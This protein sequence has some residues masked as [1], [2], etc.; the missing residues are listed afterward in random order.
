MHWNTIKSKLDTVKDRGIIR[1]TISSAS[2]KINQSYEDSSL[3]YS[4]NSNNSSIFLDKT[5]YSIYDKNSASN[6]KLYN[7]S[8]CSLVSLASNIQ[9]DLNALPN[10]IN[11]D[12]VSNSDSSPI[13]T[14]EL[15][16]HSSFSQVS[17]NKAVASDHDSNSFTHI[18]SKASTF[19]PMQ[20]SS[21]QRSS[22]SSSSSFNQ[23][24]TVSLIMTS[25][26]VPISKTIRKNNN[27]SS[28]IADPRLANQTAL[29]AMRKFND[30][31]LLHLIE[32]EISRNDDSRNDDSRNDISKSNSST[33]DTNY[34]TDQEERG[35]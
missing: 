8:I 34:S 11:N 28:Y 24:G 1:N 33:H 13:S 18:F 35:A 12:D 6:D 7:L 30:D 20:T 31:K 16:A 5:D 9:S 22:S 4:G 21:I 19:N 25:H 15:P 10:E 29:L 14:I 27:K 32:T 17:D 3:S 23:I 2:H 26:D